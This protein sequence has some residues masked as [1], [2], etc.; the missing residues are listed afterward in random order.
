MVEP[1]SLSR[2]QQLFFLRISL[3]FGVRDGL[4]RLQGVHTMEDAQGT[5]TN[6]AASSDDHC[7]ITMIIIGNYGLRL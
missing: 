1:M 6:K 2:V 7:N 3:L 4:V 5:H